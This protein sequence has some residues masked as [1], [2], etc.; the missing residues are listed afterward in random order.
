MRRLLT[1]DLVVAAL[2]A[3]Y[4]LLGVFAQGVAESLWAVFT[5]VTGLIAVA[6][7]TLGAQEDQRSREHCRARRRPSPHR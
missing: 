1:M 6:R 5:L 7:L 3:C 4:L 2:C